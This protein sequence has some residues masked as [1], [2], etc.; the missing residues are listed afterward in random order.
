[1]EKRAN[2]SPK[3]CA[4][5][6]NLTD[7]AVWVDLA[8]SPQVPFFAPLV[9]RWEAAGHRVLITSRA[10]AQTVEL[11]ERFGMQ[12]EPVGAHG[13]RGLW[14]LGGSVGRRAWLLARWAR[15]RRIAVAASHNSY[16]Q[17]LAA[18][19]LGI[20][21]MTAM[22]FEHNRANHLAFRL[23]TRV[24]VPEAFPEA[25][26][27]RF[28]G[29]RKA[30]RFPGVKEQVYLGE[31]EID[32][33]FRRRHGLR[34]GAVVA[35]VRPPADWALYH[36]FHNPVFGRLLERLAAEPGIQVVFLPRVKSQIEQARAIGGAEL[37][38]PDHAWDGPSLV[39]A[40]DIVCSAGGTMVREA[41]VLGTPAVSLF[42][43]PPIAVDAYLARLGRL[44]FL[45]S[46]DD[47]GALR[48]GPRQSPVCLLAGS[49]GVADAV[50][51]A[52]LGPLARGAAA[53]VRRN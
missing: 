41:A 2:E 33:D 43:G 52:L 38:V 24:V 7:G 18:R 42:A 45:R 32:P 27:R 39:A 6:L 4:K 11:A 9:R 47:V 23:A 1:M 13:G 48:V 15:G 40:A 51:E 35:V 26:L 50:A 28:G 8:N 5:A 10:Y 37:V 19:G 25:A 30:V 14:R 31:A 22:D 3:C 17:I 12:H 21:A 34:D 29:E 36:R 49:R 46:P 20:P 44:T 53:A 16:A